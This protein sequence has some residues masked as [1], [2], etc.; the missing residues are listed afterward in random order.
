[1]GRRTPKPGGAA[2]G[3]TLQKDQIVEAVAL[4]MSEG[5]WRPYR[6]VRELAARHNMSLASAQRYASEATRLLRLSWG[7]D[8]A[9]VAV[10]ERIAHIGREAMEREEEA[11]VFNTETKSVEVVA[12][13]KPDHRTALAAMKHLADMLGMSGTNSEVVVRYQQMSDSDLWREAQRFVAQLTGKTHDGIETS[14]ETIP[15][16]SEDSEG[17]DGDTESE[18]RDADALAEFEH[19][20]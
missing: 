10:L 1:M 5:N 3:S 17:D 9:K 20:P 8:E 11:G 6:S 19:S 12:L 2:E 14:G 15:E 13:K 4:Q 7:Q 16:P 18:A